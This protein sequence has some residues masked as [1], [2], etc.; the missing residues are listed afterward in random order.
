MILF[1]GDYIQLHDS[2]WLQV[3]GIEPYDICLL[4]NGARVCA[5][6]EYIGAV[7]SENQYKGANNGK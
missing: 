1:V 3:I 4:S 2:D 7:L 5:S 6:A